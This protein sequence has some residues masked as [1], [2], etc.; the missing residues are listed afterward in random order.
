MNP[1]WVSVDWAEPIAWLAAAPPEEAAAALLRSVALVLT[2][3]Q[4]I[5]LVV[6]GFS[7]LTGNGRLERAARRA[8]LPIWRAAAPVALV[9]GTAL[10]AVAI[11]VR[12][13]I[14]PPSATQVVDLATAPDQYDAVVV[15]PGQSMWAIAAERVDGDPSTYWRSLVHLNRDR[16]ADVDLIHPGETVLLPPLN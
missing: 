12:L 4:I 10:P 6:V 1:P 2:A 14:S 5:A 16:F 13:P 8:L 15:L 9:A 3:S 7:T 11:E